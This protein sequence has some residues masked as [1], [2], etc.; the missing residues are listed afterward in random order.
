MGRG[1][2][3]IKLKVIQRKTSPFKPPDFRC[4]RGTPSI[5]VTRGCAHRCVYCYAR[6]FPEAP[7]DGEV[8]LM[9]NLPEM[10]ERALAKMKRIPRWVS[11]STASDPFQPFEEV[12]EVTYRCMK[13]LLNSGIGV[14]FLTKGVVPDD[15]LELF[16][17]H[18]GL[19]RARVGVVSVKDDYWS[20][21]EPGSAHP[22][23]R[24]NSAKKLKE[25]GIDTSV[26][27]DPV[28]PVVSDKS[29]DIWKLLSSIKD[30]GLK[31]LTISCLVMRPS[32]EEFFRER[33]SDKLRSGI[34]GYYRRQVYQRVI[35]SARTKLLP[36]SYRRVLYKRVLS[37]AKELG[38]KV[39]ICGCKNPDLPWQDCNPWVD[40]GESA[41]LSR[42]PALW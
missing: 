16:K 9:G 19:V 1:T 25:A 40:T 31:E 39:R 21:F 37:M 15:F 17:R 18:Q 5:N 6:G 11:F 42:Q 33:L 20:V 30:A 35:T 34:L 36:L 7:P 28:V 41:Y 38:L 4:L 14:S 3:G 27:V 8:H 10:M 13:L 2:S 12:L 24:L 26:R 23:Q 29:E 32:I 22:E